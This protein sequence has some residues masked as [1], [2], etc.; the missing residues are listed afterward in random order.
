MKRNLKVRRAA[1]LMKKN[2]DWEYLLDLER[3]KIQALLE[4]LGN[5]TI[6][7]STFMKRDLNLAIRL[8]DIIKDEGYS[9][10]TMTGE[11]KFIP[12][13]EPPGVKLYTLDSSEVV[14][15][16][17]NVVNFRNFKRF[18]KNQNI[19]PNALYTEKAWN[20]YHK[21]RLYRMRTWW[22]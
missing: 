10:V 12:V 1:V 15:T 9:K 20:L 7:D 18:T 6:V 22:D 2:W 3:L 13:N 14:I 16:D 11:Y 17:N 8:I 5:S 19:S 21:L 4:H